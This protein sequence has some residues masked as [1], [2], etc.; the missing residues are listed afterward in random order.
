MATQGH[1]DEAERQRALAR[2]AILDT[3]P[4][5]PFERLTRLAAAMFKVPA[6]YIAFLDGERQWLKARL[7]IDLAETSQRDAFCAHT[8]LTPHVCVIPD[9]TE[10]P[11]FRD[12]PLLRELPWVRF[13]AGAPLTTPDG[14][15]IGTLC[16]LHTQPR[17][18]FGP[19]EQQQLK[20]LAAQVVDALDLRIAQRSVLHEIAER[21]RAEQRLVLLEMVTDTVA[22]APDSHQACVAFLGLVVQHFGAACG[23]V[24]RAEPGASVARVVTRHAESESEATDMFL[25]EVQRTEVRAGASLVWTALSQQRVVAT[26]DLSAVPR[27]AAP[28]AAQAVAAGFTSSLIIPFSD[29]Q[30]GFAMV[31]LFRALRR[32]LEGVGEGARRLALRMMPLFAQKRAEAAFRNERAF[33]GLLVQNLQA[34]IL[35]F[36]RSLRYTLWNAAMEQQTGIPAAEALGKTPE[37]LFPGLIEPPTE[38]ARRAAL[39]GR[40]TMLHDMRYRKR[41]GREGVYD[42]N[43][44]PLYDGDGRIIG[45]VVIASDTSDR[46]QLEDRLRH[47]QKMDAVGQLTGGI[48]HDFNNLLTI[49]VGSVELLGQRVARLADEPAKARLRVLLDRID[50]AVERGQKL[51]RQLLAFSRKQ[52]LDPQAL[53]LVQVLE[54]ASDMF[55][56]SLGEGIALEIERGP[57]VQPALADLNQLETAILNLLLNAR[58]AMP[59][60]GTV[61]IRIRRALPEEI[62]AGLAP[63]PGFVVLEVSDTGV[64]MAP[65]TLARAFEPFF[66]TKPVGEGSGLG[67]AQ[68]YGF[69]KQSG[70]L[71]RVESVEGSGTTVTMLLPAA[72][73][74]AAAPPPKL[75]ARET[76]ET[77]RVR[78]AKILVVEDER[79]VREVAVD[80][81]AGIGYEVIAADTGDAA[82]ELIEDGAGPDLLFSDVVMPGRFSGPELARRARRIAPAI[83]VLLTSG[84]EAR[85]PA[86]QAG[87]EPG[88]P[89]DAFLQKPYRIGTLRATVAALLGDPEP[90]SVEDGEPVPPDGSR[91]RV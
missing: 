48:A 21:R 16:I 59:E 71:A 69:A 79:A 56:Q 5:E 30:T 84:Y 6:A 85:R 42:A 23:L 68:V 37:D 90:A 41:D 70:G 58:D 65:T 55:R 4:E 57:G 83:K 60:G 19:E 50:E 72:A 78:P 33:S 38:A 36:N 22:S 75:P 76:V 7:G 18:D 11:R 15:R 34:P 13:Y 66:T 62:E 17:H 86:I 47:A 1:D 77:W 24:F 43:Y 25:A 54:G 40:T 31:L 67:L 51:T 45:G 2:L 28:F 91:Q 27:E 10:D 81:L 39:E 63:A 53:D 82:L 46:R 44:V 14:Y 80:A 3:P 74:E 88:E 52:H 89:P 61:R 20:D 32:P 49:A 26:P 87:V 9:A 29:D 35:A 64:G 73:A 8:I 12:Q